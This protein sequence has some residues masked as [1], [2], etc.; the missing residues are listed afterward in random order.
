MRLSSRPLQRQGASFPN[1]DGGWERVGS[2]V[3][4]V[5]HPRIYKEET[6]EGNADRFIYCVDELVSSVSVENRIRHYRGG[7]HAG[8]GDSRAA[9]GRAAISI[10]SWPM[11]GWLVTGE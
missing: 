1:L 3:E 4:L 9:N 11:Q 10:C 8:K 6:G 5:I 2:P 7:V